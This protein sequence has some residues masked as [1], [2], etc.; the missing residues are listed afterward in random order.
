MNRALFVLVVGLGMGMMGCAAGEEDTIVPDPAPEAQREPPRQ[1]LNAQ[2]RDPQGQ[3]LSGIEINRG[4]EN[5]PAKQ[6]PPI[7]QPQPFQ[8][9]QQA[10]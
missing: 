9:P 5:V 6:K 2:L 4:F 8:E 3:L 10:E 1:S 7:P